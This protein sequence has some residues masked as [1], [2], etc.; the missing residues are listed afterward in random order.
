VSQISPM[1]SGSAALDRYEPE[2]VTIKTDSETGGLVVFNDRMEEGW[3]VTIDGKPAT[4]LTANYLLR[5]VLVPPGRHL[6]RWQYD[7]PGLTAG[8]AISA[9]TI[10]CLFG[11]ALVN[12]KV[13]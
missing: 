6:I 10:T 5:G 2:E 3:H 9:M 1:A 4:S 11:L 12:P 8:V 13:G 7:A